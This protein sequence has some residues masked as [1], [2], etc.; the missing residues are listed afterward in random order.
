METTYTKQVH[1]MRKAKIQ[2]L[3]NQL[4]KTAAAQA[5]GLNTHKVLMA[6][7]K[8]NGT[9]EIAHSGWED[10]AYFTMLWTTSEMPE[11][12]SLNMQFSLS[13]GTIDDSARFSK[14]GKLLGGHIQCWHDRRAD[15]EAFMLWMCEQIKS[16]ED[17]QLIAR[18]EAV[19]FRAFDAV[20]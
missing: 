10:M 7:L 4:L 13:T 6:P 16:I 8:I 2:A 1:E 3:L 19:L 11:S 17:W 5:L 12:Q 9:I 15:E 14:K 20:R 18:S